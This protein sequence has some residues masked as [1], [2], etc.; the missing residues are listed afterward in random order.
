[1]TNT[2]E[3]LKELTQTTFDS[4]E[5]YRKAAEK[6][7][8]PALTRALEQRV[9]MR[10]QTLS[11]LNTALTN[12][13]E[14]AI[15]EVS[16]TGSAHQTFLTITEAFSDGDEAAVERVDEGEEYIAQKFRDAL[17]DDDIQSM[18]MSVRT[19]LQD[20]YAEISKGEKF[21]DML[22]DQYA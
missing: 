7:E 9:G 3:T 21:A 8:S 6:S 13:G 12:H 18:D 1:M 16:M 17:N 4:V 10:Q 14:E 11:K 22:E 19:L 15:S 5:G 2:V 20:A